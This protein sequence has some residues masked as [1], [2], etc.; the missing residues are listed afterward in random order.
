VQPSFLQEYL[1]AFQNIEGWFQYDAA[2]LFMA[3][4][5]LLRARG[6]EGDVLEIGVHH[7]L[8]TIALARLRGHSARV[9]AIDLF[10][11]LQE[12]NVSRSGS[13]HQAIFELNMKRFYP[14][15]SFLRVIT[16]PSNAVT[17]GELGAGFTFCNIDGGHSAEETF[18][19][20]KLC[21]DIAAAGGL[22]ALDD[23]FNPAYPGVC[24][25]A[26]AF[27][28]RHPGALHPLVIAYN[29]VLFRKGASPADLNDRFLAAFP[30]IKCSTITMWGCP[31]I[32]LDSVLRDFLDLHASTPERFV[33]AGTGGPRAVITPAVTELNAR[34]GEKLALK[35]EIENVSSEI[36]PCG[37]QEFGLSYH[38]STEEG[39]LLRYDNDRS[40]IL[41]PLQPGQRQQVTLNLTAPE[42]RGE[43]VLEL[44]LVWEQVMWFKDVHNPTAAVKLSLTD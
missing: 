16:R 42:E 10:E 19:D 36:F 2:L 3:Y 30:G 40:W 7:G 29:K 13:G 4:N 43:Y 28:L 26:V 9:V 15:A 8:S 38:L 39:A 1:K 12:A 23:Y 17:A 41:T 24:E 18:N 33:P 35:V 44:D 27:H 37:T 14:N 34:R 25:G 11:N 32:L 6:I 31:V 20:L 21:H 5:Q 22:I